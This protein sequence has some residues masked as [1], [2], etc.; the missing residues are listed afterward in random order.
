MSL[1]LTH[2]DRALHRVLELPDIAW[3]RVVDDR[4]QSRST[5][6]ELSP[7]PLAAPTKEGVGDQD[8]VMAPLA[9]R[10]ELQV[11]D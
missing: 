11:D 8:D 6:L 5:E 2:D 10:R 1:P 9:E 4:L 3:P 7:M